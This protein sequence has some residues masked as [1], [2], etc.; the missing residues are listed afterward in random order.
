MSVLWF[1]F[2]AYIFVLN[3]VDAERI[4]AYFPTPSISHQVV[5]R[6]LTEA[7]AR[8]GHEVTV[9]TTDPAFPKGGTPP[10]LTEIDVHNLS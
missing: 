6:P 3:Q 10:N 9:V 4:L 5:F 8:R 2:A 7:L 1:I